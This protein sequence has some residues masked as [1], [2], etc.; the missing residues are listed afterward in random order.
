MVPPLENPP[1]GAWHCPACPELIP[2]GQ[3]SMNPT[4]QP[5]S[6]SPFFTTKREVSVASTSRSVA[7]VRAPTRGRGRKRGAGRGRGGV[8]RVPIAF[9]NSD[10]EEIGT[11]ALSKARGR[12]KSNAKGKARAVTLSSDEEPT[13]SSVRSLKRKRTHQLSPVIP[14]PRVRLRLPPRGKGKERE[15]E[16]PHGLF[17]DILGSAERDT[18]KTSITNL[19][20]A[21][22]ERS[23]LSAE[24]SPRILLYSL[25]SDSKP[26]RK[27][28]H[29]LLLLQ[30]QVHR[31]HL[32]LLNFQ[33]QTID[34]SDLPRSNTS[35]LVSIFQILQPLP[36]LEALFPNLNLA[37]SEYVASVLVNTTSR[38]GMMHLSLKNMHLYQM[39]DSGYASFA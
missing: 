5:E 34:L 16:D 14:L 12:I 1:E 7:E 8:P 38:R 2:E 6:Q 33:R 3:E 21:Y 17:D 13:V 35:L 27:N 22:F 37:S 39:D 26:Y 32:M 30:Q 36:R 11:P 10:G 19:D 25:I 9:E 29:L 28:L 15:E 4:H 20:K 24:V 18:S 23:R 31:E